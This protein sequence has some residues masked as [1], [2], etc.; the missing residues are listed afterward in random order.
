MEESINDVLPDPDREQGYAMQAVCASYTLQT[1]RLFC[2][3]S[4]SKR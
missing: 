2:F 3:P 4:A 1:T